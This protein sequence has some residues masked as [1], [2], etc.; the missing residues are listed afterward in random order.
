MI[1][2]H[3]FLIYVLYLY[4]LFIFKPFIKVI[5]S[6]HT[7]KRTFCCSVIKSLWLFSPVWM[8]SDLLTF[9]SGGEDS[10]EAWPIAQFWWSGWRS[11][12]WRGRRTQQLSFWSNPWRWVQ[13]CA[14]L[15]RAHALP[16]HG[17][18]MWSKWSHGA[19]SGVCGNGERVG[20]TVY[21]EPEERV[22]RWYE[23]RATEDVWDADWTSQAAIT[24]S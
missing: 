12:S 14:E 1:F 10:R 24:S 11:W 3:L 17:G 6:D 22:H 15:C 9:F 21:L 8:T 13:R 20:E 5:F 23:I 19:H 7:V 16:T 4:Y 2:L 18:G